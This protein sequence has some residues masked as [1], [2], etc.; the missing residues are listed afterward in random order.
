MVRIFTNQ[1]IKK[2][3]LKKLKY[4]II[5]PYFVINIKIKLFKNVYRYQIFDSNMG[6][7]LWGARKGNLSITNSS[8]SGERMY[9]R[10]YT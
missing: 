9:F 3:T 7:N 8:A 6:V 2:Y 5:F 1:I 10:F 4:M